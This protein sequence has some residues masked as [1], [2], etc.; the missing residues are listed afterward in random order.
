MNM[1]RIFSVA[2]AEVREESLEKPGEMV[3][4]CL[5]VFQRPHEGPLV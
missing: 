3:T 4:F 2:N 5:G 1:P